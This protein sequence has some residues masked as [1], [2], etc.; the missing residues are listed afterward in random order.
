[1]SRIL[2]LVDQPET[3]ALLSDVLKS[4]Y[5]VIAGDHEQAFN[6]LFDLCIVDAAMIERYAQ[7]IRERK[8]ADEPLFLP[9][10]LIISRKAL[11]SLPVQLR[12]IADDVITTPVD[13]LELEA[14]VESLTRA[15]RLS[16]EVGQVNERLKQE[17]AVREQAEETLR[18]LEEAGNLLAASIDYETTLKNLGSLIVPRLADCYMVDIVDKW[19]KLQRVASSAADT[20]TLHLLESLKQHPP[21]VQELVTPLLVSDM[22]GRMPDTGYWKLAKTIN[23]RSFIMVPLTARARTVGSLFLAVSDN[24]LPYNQDSLVLIIEIARRTAQAIDNAGL[25]REVQSALS[26]RDDFLSVAGHELRTP[27]TGI[28]GFAQVLLA[29]VDKL[30]DSVPPSLR[31]G[32]QRIDEQAARLARLINSLLDASRLQAGNLELDRQPGDLVELVRVVTNLAQ[33]NTTK[34][35]IVLKTPDAIT[36][37]IDSLRIEQVFTNLI[38]NAVKYSPNGGMV[39][40]E[41]VLPAPELAQISVTDQGIGIAPMYRDRIFDR[42]YQ[43]PASQNSKGIGLGL[44]LSRQI[45]ELHGGFITVE[46]PEAGGTRFVVTLPTNGIADHTTSE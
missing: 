38:D 21:P 12:H 25:H 3:Q 30:G 36:I 23:A 6:A 46:S 17:I 29:R 34:H 8:A 42:Y 10:L 24:R 43:V 44:Y 35:T 28:R 7:D 19:G 22:S 9:V 37:S 27:I 5:E 39:W 45:I 14:R 13:R 16:L 31:Q 1:V 18:F 33:N 41:I 4:R 2:L 32:I 11:A 40:V 26:A 15:R 20:F